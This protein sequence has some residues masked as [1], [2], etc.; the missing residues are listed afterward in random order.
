M[1]FSVL[2]SA[3]SLTQRGANIFRREVGVKLE[4]LLNVGT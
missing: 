2:Q 3:M 1:G 4:D